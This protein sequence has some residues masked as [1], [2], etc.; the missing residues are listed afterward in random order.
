MVGVVEAVD[1]DSAF[2][3]AAYAVAVVAVVAVVAAV[4]EVNGGFENCVVD[5]IS[6]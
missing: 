1:D 3:A 5:V 6:R 4:S 2:F